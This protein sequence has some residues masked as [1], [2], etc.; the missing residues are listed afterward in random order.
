MILVGT[1][2]LE[3]WRT[4]PVIKEAHIDQAALDQ[5]GWCV[6]ETIQYARKRR[7]KPYECVEQVKERILS[8]LKGLTAPIYA[9][10]NEDQPAL[11]NSFMHTRHM[12]RVIPQEYLNDIG[13]GMYVVAPQVAVLQTTYSGAPYDALL[14]MYELCGTYGRFEPTPRA[15][16]VLENLVQEGRWPG[17]SSNERDGSV[18]GVRAGAMDDS[19]WVPR[20]DDQGRPNGIWTRPPLISSE[21]IR[22]IVPQHKGVGGII[23]YRFVANSVRDGSCSPLA[24]KAAIALCSIASNGGEA[25]PSPRFS[26]EVPQEIVC[27]SQDERNRCEGVLLWDEQHVALVVMNDAP[28]EDDGV[29]EPEYRLDGQYAP[30]TSDGQVRFES[31]DAFDTEIKAQASGG[32][33]AFKV[34]EGQMADEDSLETLI[35]SLSDTLGFQRSNRSTRFCYARKNMHAALFPPKWQRCAYGEYGYWDVYGGY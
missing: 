4:P 9:I 16:L 25:W 10:V 27:L 30:Q 19:A 24:T 32:Y 29:L 31:A 35:A 21:D 15:A 13:D 11:Y 20:F 5:D 8:D 3:W 6:D 14:L 18:D 28:A 12:K 34:T 22:G 33:L 17:D 2:A 7:A 26:L 23:D 1:S